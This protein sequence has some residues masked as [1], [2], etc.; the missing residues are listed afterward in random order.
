MSDVFVNF[1]FMPFSLYQ[2]DDDDDRA[3]W[4][5]LDEY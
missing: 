2:D 1:I 5:Q 3:S 4:Q